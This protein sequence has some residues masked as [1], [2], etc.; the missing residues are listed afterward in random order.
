MNWYKQA[1]WKEMFERLLQKF[2]GTDVGGKTYKSITGPGLSPSKVSKPEHIV[3]GKDTKEKEIRDEYFE[4]LRLHE[5]G[6]YQ[7][8]FQ[9]LKHVADVN[10]ITGLP[11]REWEMYEERQDM[12]QIAL[13]IDN[14]KWM[15]DVKLT[16]PGADS[17]IAVVSELLNKIP[18]QLKDSKLFHIHGDEF[19]VVVAIP[20]KEKH[21][22]KVI[23]KIDESKKVIEAI[24]R[25][26]QKYLITN[27]ADPDVGASPSV[28]AAISF[29]YIYADKAVSNEKQ[30][31]KALWRPWYS[32]KHVVEAFDIVTYRKTSKQAPATPLPQYPPQGK[33]RT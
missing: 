19:A 17:A 14:L 4:S 21:V 32:A 5:A 10:K 29:K 25:E 3:P 6:D 15:N 31:R 30:R 18:T 2:V 20:D 11:S 22:K 9:L 27:P 26:I 23:Q 8:A 12:L 33:A 7:K 1:G 16:H 28:T 13:D 24:I